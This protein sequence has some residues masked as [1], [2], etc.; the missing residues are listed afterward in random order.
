MQAICGGLAAPSVGCELQTSP[1]G[2]S[3]DP[4]LLL[5]SLNGCCHLK[6]ARTNNKRPVGRDKKILG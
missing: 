5:A 4:N 3:E 6:T 2:S 1:C